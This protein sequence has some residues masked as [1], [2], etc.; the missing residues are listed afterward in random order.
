MYLER[1]GVGCAKGK[2]IRS[3][4]PKKEGF[5]GKRIK[6]VLTRKVKSLV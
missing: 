3:Y 5:L 4:R 1:V 2:K 6:K